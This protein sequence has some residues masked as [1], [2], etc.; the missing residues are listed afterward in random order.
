MNQSQKDQMTPVKKTI[1]IV[2][3]LILASIAYNRLSILASSSMVPAKIVN[4]DSQWVK[5]SSSSSSS[6]SS[7]TRDKVQYIPQALAENG[8][9]VS[10][11]V[12][13]PTRALCS[14]MVGKNVTVLENTSAPEQNR[15]YSFVQFWALSLFLAF[16]PLTYL[17]GLY[18]ISFTR[19]T[20]FVIFVVLVYGTTEEVGLI[21]KY[22]PEQ[23]TEPKL[24]SES[25]QGTRSK[26]SPDKAALDRCV[27][28]AMMGEKVEHRSQIKR[29]VCQE[30]DISDISSISDI[31]G[32]EKL[33]LQGN[34]LTS[35]QQLLPLV[36]LKAISVAG[37]K[38]L[39]STKGIEY[40]SKLEEFQGNKSAISDLSGFEQLSQLKVIGLM[41]NKISDV[42]ALASLTNLEEVI[43]SYNSISDVSA[44]ANHKNLVKVS[45]SNN[46]IVD[47]SAFSNKPK[48][49]WF[50]IYSNPV[51]DISPLY[52]N[53]KMK[54]FGANT[55]VK[56]EQL[57]R[58]KTLL[59]SDAKVWGMDKCV[60]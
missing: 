22:F 13:L 51:N 43:L 36:N 19:F 44:F 8:T 53:L 57:A 7:N 28:K 10:G 54:I 45:L 3:L 25:K 46:N 42:S 18:S 2:M 58:M 50:T 5:V 31:T 24:G 47:V 1:A 55:Y 21:K 48:L 17:I 4:C 32:L 49:N 59:A 11:S 12:M 37:N 34:N 52:T 9:K 40:A 15:I 56:C 29:L 41:D 20:A 6:L 33:Y 38:N 27:F 26:H 35:L 16:A 39:T 14:Q 23:V 30:E 60:K